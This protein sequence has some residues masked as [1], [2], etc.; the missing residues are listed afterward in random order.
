MNEIAL[1]EP[2]S[3]TPRTDKRSVLVMD[4]SI[5]WGDP[6]VPCHKRVPGMRFLLDKDASCE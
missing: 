1:P 6:E 4:G 3:I 2:E 5:R